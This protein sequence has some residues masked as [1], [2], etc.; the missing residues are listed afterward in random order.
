MTE[1]KKVS[2]KAEDQAEEQKTFDSVVSEVE[3]AEKVEESPTP[4]GKGIPEPKSEAV[5]GKGEPAATPK[6][7]TVK[8]ATAP[9]PLITDTDVADEKVV[10]AD[11]G[12]AA[13]F[14]EMSSEE[15]KLSVADRR[16]RISQALSRGLVNDWLAV[17]DAPPDIRCVWVRER[18]EDIARRRLLGYE[19]EMRYGEQYIDH[20][21]GDSVRRFGDCVLMSTPM[22]N[23]HFIL[24]VEAER[25]K[26]IHDAGQR[27]FMEGTPEVPGLSVFDDSE[28]IG[29]SLT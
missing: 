7:P 18:R 29:P 27:E 22:D 25:K 13:E 16:A 19:L 26:Q 20:A 15:A 6:V 24:E 5:S 12:V 8:P 17:T 4:S 1:P 10:T 3:G 14:V 21:R 23:Y 11:P 9:P 2:D 28:E